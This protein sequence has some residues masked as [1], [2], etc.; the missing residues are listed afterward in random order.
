MKTPEVQISNL[1]KRGEAIIQGLQPVLEKI[2]VQLSH[3]DLFFAGRPGI[4]I[5]P[6][7]TLSTFLS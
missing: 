6:P 3:P 7:N 4:K 1:A 2:D 5:R